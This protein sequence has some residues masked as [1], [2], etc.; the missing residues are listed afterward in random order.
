MEG[1]SKRERIYISGEHCLHVLWC[2]LGRGVV[3]GLHCGVKYGVGGGDRNRRTDFENSVIRPVFH[4]KN[5]IWYLSKKCSNF[6]R[7]KHTINL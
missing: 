5:V 3:H 7:C 6:L 1:L 4:K 2:E